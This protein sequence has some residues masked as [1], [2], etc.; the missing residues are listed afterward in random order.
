MASFDIVSKVDI[1]LVDNAVNV[2]KK[3]LDTRYDLRGTNSEIL[4]DKKAEVIAVASNNDMNVGSIVKIVLSQFTKQKIDVNSLDL[5]KKEY[6]SGSAVK[7]DIPIKQGLDKETCKKITKL[8]KDS[9][10]KVKPQTMDDVIRVSGKSLNDLQAV[11]AKCRV[12]ELDVPLQ[13]INMK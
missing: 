4:L 5:S 2:A 6:A 7:K 11:I 10:L 1:Q 12:A 9:K 8:I 13:F 3:E